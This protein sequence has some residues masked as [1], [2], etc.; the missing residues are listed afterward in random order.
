M[1]K[2]QANYAELEALSAYLDGQLPEHEA[3][4]VQARL[5]TD[6]AYRE[7]LTTLRQTRY[8]L[9][10]TPKVKRPRSFVLSP[11]MVRKQKAAVFGMNF[12]RVISAAASVLLV[13]VL[14]G[15]F[16]LGGG[17][18]RAAP[19]PYDVAYDNSAEPQMQ[20]ADEPAEAM[21][22]E[23]PMAEAPLDEGDMA[24]AAEPAADDAVE[25][26]VEEPAAEEAPL[27]ATEA[28]TLE[29]TSEPGG[30]GGLPPTE[31]PEPVVEATATAGMEGETRSVPN[32]KDTPEEDLAP[33]S[34]AEDGDVAGLELTQEAETILAEPP[35]P[36]QP[37]YSLSPI[38][39]FQA[40]LLLL[41]IGGGILAAYFR[42]RVR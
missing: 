40:V 19:E 3:E 15:Q 25:E 30:G 20:M 12:S 2:D 17:G 33:D 42:K 9:R 5:E 29:G 16:L 21:E 24:G 37:R 8:T 7:Q 26:P 34:P 18:L 28:P 36:V 22:M 4:A 23:A 38:G 39:I 41:A 32:Q 14:G 31:E 35:P 27:M 1:K 11:E 10:R 6:A 13:V